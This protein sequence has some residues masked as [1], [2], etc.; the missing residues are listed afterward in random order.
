MFSLKENR[1]KEVKKNLKCHIKYKT[2]D[3]EITQ[4]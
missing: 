3:T 1:F 4:I 2:K